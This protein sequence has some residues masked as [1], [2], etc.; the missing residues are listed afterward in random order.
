VKNQS[1]LVC[2]I[3]LLALIGCES[4]KINPNPSTPSPINTQSSQ[5]AG[6]GGPVIDLG[7]TKIGPFETKATRDEGEIVAGKDAPIDVTV[8][9]AE[10][11]KI[12][13]VR[14]WIGNE[15]ARVSIK[16]LASIENPNE[17]NRWHTHA[18]IPSPIPPDSKLWVEIEDEAGTKHVGN[19]DLKQ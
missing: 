15:D 9:P 17:P 7:S 3:G 16:A 5:T 12:K 6:H 18:E 13:A 1:L 19:Y 4:K 10:D 8:T 14:F 2:S 11:L